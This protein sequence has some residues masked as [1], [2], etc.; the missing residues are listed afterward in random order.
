MAAVFPRISIVTPSFN[1]AAYVE[2]TVRSVLGQRYPNLEYLVLDGGST[3]GTVERMAPYLAGFA[4]FRSSPDGG[5][6]AALAEGF[7]RS[8]GEIMAYLNSDDV[9][10]PGTLAFVA[11]YFAAH[12]H[13]DF[14]YGHRAIIDDANIVT[15]HWI[16]PRHRNYLME[17]DDFIPQ[18][19]SFWRRSLFERAGNID[20]VYSFAMDYDLFVRYMREGRFRR[21][22]RFLA[23]YRMHSASKTSLVFEASGR[24]EIDL[25]RQRHGLVPYSRRLG[26]YVSNALRLRSALFLYA[27]KRFAGLPSGTGYS[28]DRVWGGLLEDAGIALP[29]Q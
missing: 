12:P 23:A 2:W 8:T 13:V 27:G 14:I 19:G 20:P 26:D 21:V 28:L 25:V 1:Q 17:R 4:H 10:L 22:N 18:E 15:G 3:D 5:Q 9:L 16:L 11:E 7:A 6:A 29:A 24:A